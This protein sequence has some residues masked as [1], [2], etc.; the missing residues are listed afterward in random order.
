MGLMVVDDAVVLMTT[1]YLR[2]QSTRYFMGVMVDDDTD[3][4]AIVVKTTLLENDIK[5]LLYGCDG[6][7]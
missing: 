3:H 4:D 6:R 7:P 2:M 5:S 1:P